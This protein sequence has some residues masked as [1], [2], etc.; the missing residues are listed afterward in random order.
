M[1]SEHNPNAGENQTHFSGNTE[2]GGGASIG[3]SAGVSDGLSE[4][5]SM[6]VKDGEPMVTQSQRPKSYR[7]KAGK[8]TCGT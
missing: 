3:D 7:D 6:P 8:F 1:K 5:S 4:V 2:G